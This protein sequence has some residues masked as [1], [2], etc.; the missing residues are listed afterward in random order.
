MLKYKILIKIHNFVNSFFIYIY[1]RLPTNNLNLILKSN[2]TVFEVTD[3]K[4]YK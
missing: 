2:N 1:N 4:L 3:N